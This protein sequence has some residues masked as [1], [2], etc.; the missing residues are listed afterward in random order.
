MSLLLRTSASLVA[1]QQHGELK[2]VKIDIKP[3]KFQSENLSENERSKS[4]Y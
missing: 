4:N 1:N 2:D 3:I